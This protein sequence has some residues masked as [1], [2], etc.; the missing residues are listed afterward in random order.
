MST[1]IHIRHVNV[2]RYV[3][4]LREGGSLPAIAEADDDFLY[5]V[6]FSG[7][8]Q[9]TKA[10]IADFIGGEF[11]KILGLKMPELVFA[12][13]DPCFGR[14]EADEEIQDLLKASTGINLG[15]HYLK[16][17]ITYDPSVLKPSHEVAAKI[18]WL[19]SFIF[20]V[21]RTAKNSNMLIW[22][23]EIWL[24]DHGS[25]LYFH[26]NWT[27]RDSYI[28]RPF[29][30]WKDHIFN[31]YKDFV[32]DIKDHCVQLLSDEVIDDI[33]DALPN[34]WL[35]FR[36]VTERSEEIKSSYKTF[37]KKR[38]ALTDQWCRYE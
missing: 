32:K 3:T 15:V 20:N 5:V 7:S 26:H 18:L 19:D 23:K 34:E 37:F 17:A 10:L 25:S 22:H 33:V 28:D 1:P 4:P 14:S 2:T 16:G 11:A 30:H 21:D 24:I 29:G 8:G 6:K 36:G 13:L 9:G 31:D 12:S 38:L 35:M 27:Q